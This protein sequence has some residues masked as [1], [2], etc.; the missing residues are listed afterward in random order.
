MIPLYQHFARYNRWANERLYTSVADLS[1]DEFGRNCAAFFG[2]MRGTLN[3]LLVAD[4]IWMRRLTGEGPAPTALDTILFER[5][6]D[7]RA[8][9]AEEDA[10]I[11]D[12]VDSLDD[13]RLTAPLAFASLAGA[14]DERPLWQILSHL[15]NHETH[16]RGQA[17]T[18]LSQ[19]G[20]TPPPLDF[21]IFVREMK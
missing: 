20:R 14:P 21:Y 18:L 9:R 5:F 7:L 3:H 13:A 10:K 2:S 8:A 11:V 12:Y 15:F 6:P 1:Q 16:H 4:R 17:H 19:M